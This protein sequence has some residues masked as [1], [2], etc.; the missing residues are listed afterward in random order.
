MMPIFLDAKPQQ[1]DIEGKPHVIR[2]V[3]G[4]KTVLINGHPYRTEFGGM[5]M[6]IFVEGIKHFVRLTV[7]PRGIVPGSVKIRNMPMG[8]GRSNLQEE[9]EEEEIEQEEVM[10]D[11]EHHQPPP[12][13]EQS[14]TKMISPPPITSENS[15][16]ASL[17][18]M[19]EVGSSSAFDKLLPLFPKS[20]D[21][22]KEDPSSENY[23]SR[24]QD[25]H[26]EPPPPPFPSSRE[27]QKPQEGEEEDSSS[28]N[29]DVH[30]LW[31]QLLGAGLVS[32]EA[33]N[34]SSAG[35]KKKGIPGLDT[36][37]LL[38]EDAHNKE[39]MNPM[40]ES[41]NSSTAP[42]SGAPSGSKRET[43]KEPVISPITLKSHHNSL[44]ERQQS[45]V[46][47]LYDPSAL[48]CKNCGLRYSPLDMISYSQHLDWHFRMKR[49][50][51]DNAKKAQSR[52]WYFERMDWIVSDEIEEEDKENT[53]TEPH[54]T[55]KEIPT[56][57]ARKSTEENTCPVCKE[58]F[59]EFYKDDT[60][61]DGKWLLYNAVPGENGGI[62]H[63][64]CLQD[65][66]VDKSS[67][68]EDEEEMDSNLN[69]STSS[70]KEETEDVKTVMKE[71]KSEPDNDVEMKEEGKLPSEEDI[72]TEGDDDDKASELKVEVKEE[73]SVDN[74]E[75]KEEELP[76]G[77]EGPEGGDPSEESSQQAPEPSEEVE[78]DTLDGMEDNS[79][80][81]LTAPKTIRVNLTTPLP[82][83]GASSPRLEGSPA[84]PP[85][86]TEETKEENDSKDDHHINEENKKEV[87]NELDPDAIVQNIEST[88][89]DE[90]RKPGLKGKKLIEI[91]TQKKDSEL[92]GL[93]A[94]M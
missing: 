71:I 30:N 57:P 68:L 54:E 16:G 46:N 28:T 6:V 58:E 79:L 75:N 88:E 60:D 84:P 7:L 70:V 1:F 5:P 65:L 81:V 31:K 3:E 77:E 64:Q 27:T 37:P 86:T 83:S 35:S 43:P 90:R 56:V 11:D 33:N 26:Q 9:K 50:E 8:L 12:F 61:E 62:Y 15:N 4:L 63:P 24:E 25:S 47:L 20:D 23:K 19:D 51:K 93:C 38:E 32:G 67:P 40:E 29:V 73:P 14:S 2:F 34:G 36:S 78:E 44:K 49:R 52:R 87:D 55:E 48:Q 10:E 89:E 82:G 85:P 41:A 74:E 92:S 59:E 76:E 39:N 45:V 22:K 72:K 66:S 53:N 91:P 21:K 17:E 94:I 69:E 18:N 13:S 80:P 42:S